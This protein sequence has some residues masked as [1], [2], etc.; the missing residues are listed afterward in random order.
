MNGVLIAM[1]HFQ[2]GG[3]GMGSA[4]CVKVSFNSTNT[5]G[6]ALF[7][8]FRMEEIRDQGGK[9]TLSKASSKQQSQDLPGSK[10]CALLSPTV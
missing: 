6:P 2:C 1:G 7:P 5:P 4:P 9:E 10:A 8:C 3:G